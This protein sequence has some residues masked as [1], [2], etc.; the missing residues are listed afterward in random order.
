MAVNSKYILIGRINGS[1]SSRRQQ[2][3]SSETAARKAADRWES[4]E[5]FNTFWLYGPRAA[6]AAERPIVWESYNGKP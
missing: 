1:S 2:A 6:A 3:Y 4:S 5:G